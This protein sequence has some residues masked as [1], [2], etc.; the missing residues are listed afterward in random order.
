MLVFLGCIDQIK[1]SS[2]LRQELISTE[3][4]LYDPPQLLG[5]IECQLRHVLLDKMLMQQHYAEHM[6]EHRIYLH[7]V[8]GRCI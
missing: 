6:V 2:V 5:S 7:F 1:I 4:F 8:G 3:F